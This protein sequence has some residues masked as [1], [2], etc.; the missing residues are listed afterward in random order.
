MTGTGKRIKRAQ[1]CILDA[2]ALLHDLVV[3]VEDG[4]IPEQLA[5]ICDRAR[6]ILA[7]WDAVMQEI[8]GAAK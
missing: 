8:R 4:L 2:Y 3:A 6:E 7:R 5:A 1:Q